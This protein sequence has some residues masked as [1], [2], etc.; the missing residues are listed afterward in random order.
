MPSEDNHH[1]GAPSSDQLEGSCL[2]CAH[3]GPQA[4]RPPHTR[5][6]R[7][8]GDTVRSGTCARDSGAA[9]DVLGLMLERGSAPQVIF[10]APRMIGSLLLL[11]MERKRKRR[12]TMGQH[13]QDEVGIPLARQSM[14][15]ACKTHWCRAQPARGRQHQHLLA[16]YR[17]LPAASLDLA[18]ATSCAM[19]LSSSSESA[20]SP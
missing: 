11:S 1:C 10:R 12:E 20:A 4:R 15:S 8:K 5:N 6:L 13:G 7:E 9:S 3:H 18:F 14:L 19:R 16:I 17:P 2:I